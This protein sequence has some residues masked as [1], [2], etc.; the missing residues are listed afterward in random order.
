[1]SLVIQNGRIVTATDDFTGDVLIEAKAE[2]TDTYEMNRNLVLTDGAR[3]TRIITPSDF[4]RRV[5][6]VRGFLFGAGASAPMFRLLGDIEN[7]LTSLDSS[8]AAEDA[9]AYARASIYSGFFRSVVLKNNDL[10]DPSGRVR[11]ER[12]DDQ[13]GALRVLLKSGRA[14][15]RPERVPAH[16]VHHVVVEARAL[17][18]LHAHGDALAVALFG[19][20]AQQRRVVLA[21]GLLGLELQVHRLA[22]AAAFERA[23]ERRGDVPVAAVQVGDLRGPGENGIL[24]VAHLDA[25]GDHGVAAYERRRLTR[26]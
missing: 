9:K 19:L 26:S 13:P 11:V 22:R 3:A 24:R 25:Q 20:D 2:G 23:L 6:I 12:I 15:R 10:L 4:L 21:E 16:R 18:D 5:V 8:D 17:L 14:H 1:M 7:L